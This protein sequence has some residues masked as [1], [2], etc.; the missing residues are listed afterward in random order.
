MENL[1]GEIDEE[2]Y[3]KP[4]KVRGAF[5]DNY[6]EY[7]RKGDRDKKLSVKEYLYMITPYLRDM[8]NY[9]KAPMKLKF[10]F[11]HKVIDYKTQFG[12]WKIQL[13]MQ[14]KFICSK[15]SGETRIMHTW[16]NNVEIIMGSKTD[17]VINELFRSFLQNYQDKSMNG[18]QF[19]FESVDLL[20]YYIHKI[21]L[22]RDKS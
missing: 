14:T 4:I 6:I 22:K 17:S 1:L 12:E 19:K 7:E 16:S 2:D 20:Y 21:S 5:N 11:R 18:S 9:H 10:H 3:Y 8:V 15:D 13:E